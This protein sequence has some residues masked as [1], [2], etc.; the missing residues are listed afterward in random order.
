MLFNVEINRVATKTLTIQVEASSIDDAAA[1]AETQ[2]GE[3]D[4]SAVSEKSP[5][6]T[7]EY[8]SEV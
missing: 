7:V 5:E 1:I 3:L 4:F 2:F 8:V 6:Y